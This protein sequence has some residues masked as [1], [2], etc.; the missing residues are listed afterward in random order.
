[1]NRWSAVLTAVFTAA[2]LAACSKPAKQKTESAPPEPKAEATVA[3]AGGATGTSSPASPQKGERDIHTPRVPADKLPEAK[4]MKSPFPM[5]AENLAK[6]KAIYTGKGT[7]FT[8][9]GNEG[10]GDG[11]VGQALVPSPRNF[12]NPEFTKIRTP[13]EMFWVVKNGSPGTGMVGLVPA[14]ITEDEAW[15]AVMYERSL[16]GAKN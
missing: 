15:L 1:M 9:H 7:C 13:G 6:G 2:S 12:T 10:K 5:N 4:A 11:I 8:C 3:E 16:G 14:T